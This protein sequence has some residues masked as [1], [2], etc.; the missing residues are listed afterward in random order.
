MNH[1]IVLNYFK[2]ISKIPRATG[3]EKQISN[4]IMNFAKER[5]LEVMQDE[6]YNL[7]I[8]KKSTIK[9]YNGLTVILQGHMDMVYEK[10]ED[11]EHIYENGIE[12]IEKDGYLYGNKTTLGS[13]NGIAIAYFLALIDNE[14]IKHPDLKMIIT[15][16]EEGGLVGAKNLNIDN[17]KGNYL[18]NL[19]AEEEGTFITSCAGGVRN[20]LHIPYTREIIRGYEPLT[21]H[22][23]GLKGGHSGLDI[24]KGR[25]NAIRLMAR[26]L[27]YINEENIHLLSINV[28]GKANAIPAKSKATIMV[29]KNN[30]EEVISR[31]Q[32]MENVFKREF[33]LTDKNLA[34]DIIE[35]ESNSNTYNAY[36]KKDQDK[37]INA[38]MLL[39][40]GVLN[41]SFDIPDLVQ[42]S[43]NTGSIEEREDR[44]SV[45][46]SIR[47]S[48]RSEKTYIMNVIEIIGDVFNINCE[49]FNDYPEWEYKSDSKFRNLVEEVY[50]TNFNKKPKMMAM[51][52][53]LECGYFSNR[54]E[55]I[56]IISFGP[57]L[58][59]VH[60]TKEHVSIQSIKNTWDFLVKLLERL[61]EDNN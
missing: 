14:E 43:I 51:H 5:N 22:I 42:T 9:N 45:L 17:I 10:E 29:E 19:D 8:N 55:D 34:I 60:T 25:G 7:I 31:I 38:L 46:S 57:D 37:I 52:A 6:F 48:V 13:D 39:P 33:Y 49:F 40:S 32:F 50:E 41:K 3:D 58:H 47:S 35:E 54:L 4:Y 11:S 61:G 16:Q 53:G 36:A 59:Q 27:Y 12:I 24:D 56:D 23:H 21:I 15:A 30:K 28:P 1:K 2:E 18:I 20:Y 44:I 26:L